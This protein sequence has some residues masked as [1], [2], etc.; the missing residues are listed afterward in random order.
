MYVVEVDLPHVNEQL[1][2]RLF[3]NFTCV[4]ILLY[5][6]KRKNILKK[7]KRVSLIFM[8]IKRAPILFL[9]PRF[10]LS[11]TSQN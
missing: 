3:K 11:T 6:R 4:N 10:K 7:I 5:N 2:W 8:I 9:H 1:Q